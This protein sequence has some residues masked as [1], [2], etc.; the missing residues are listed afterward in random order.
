MTVMDLY[1]V[2]LI[3]QKVIIKDKNKDRKVVYNGNMFDI[4]L[5]IL[6]RNIIWLLSD[7]Y[8]NTIELIIE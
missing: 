4:P 8:D 2:T 1:M 5:N 7:I 6:D 3:E